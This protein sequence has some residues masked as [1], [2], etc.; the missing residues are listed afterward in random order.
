VS[1]FDPDAIRARVEAHRA[2]LHDYKGR[3][4]VCCDGCELAD[5]LPALLDRI[6]EM[7]AEAK[8]LRWLER[9]AHRAAL[10]AEKESEESLAVAATREAELA[11]VRADRAKFRIAEFDAENPGVASADI[12]A[13]GVEA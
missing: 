12:A 4:V 11:R 1:V 10:E 6:A 9:S 5:E 8:K 13:K 2:E 3:R 7:A